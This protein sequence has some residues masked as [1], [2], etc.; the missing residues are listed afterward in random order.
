MAINIGNQQASV[1]NNVEGDQAIYGGQHASFTT[2]DLVGRLRA[3]LD[4]APLHRQ[5]LRSARRELAAIETAA[6][7]PAPD[8]RSMAS[9]LGQLVGIMKSAGAL[10]S[11]S[12]SLITTLRALGTTLGPLGEPVRHMLGI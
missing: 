9:H 5:A 8:K 3:E 6:T 7:Q 1:V 12:S 4:R 10:T 11:A 2:G